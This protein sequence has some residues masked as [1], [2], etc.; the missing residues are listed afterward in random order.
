MDEQVCVQ[1]VRTLTAWH[2][3][4]SPPLLC[5]MQ[6]SI[7]MSCRPRHSGKAVAYVQT[8][9]RT[10]YVVYHLRHLQT[11]TAMIITTTIKTAAPAALAM[12]TIGRLSAFSTVTRQNSH[13]LCDFVILF[14]IITRDSVA[15]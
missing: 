8:D 1:L 5:A 3:P 6:Q 2:C 7:D 11:M 12:I 14:K 4:H 13:D 15:A 9:R 10:V